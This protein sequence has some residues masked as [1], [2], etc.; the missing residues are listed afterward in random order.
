MCV[1]VFVDAG[2]IMY[3]HLSYN[4][5]YVNLINVYQDAEYVISGSESVNLAAAFGFLLQNFGWW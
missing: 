3:W 4:S 5:K 2:K 1:L